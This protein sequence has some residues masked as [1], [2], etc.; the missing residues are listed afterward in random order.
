MNKKKKQAWIEKGYTLVA[1]KG[2]KSL[3]I[4]VIC[5]MMDKSKSSF[6]HYFGDLEMFEEDLVKYHLERAHGFAA[7]IDN[8][9]RA[10]PNFIA[11]LL[12]H[13]LDIFFYKAFRM[14][15]RGP[16]FDHYHQKIFDLYEGA[17][18]EKWA[19]HFDLENKMMLLAQFNKFLSEH[20]ILSISFDN[21]THDWVK[22]YLK[23]VS[24]LVRQMKM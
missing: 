18:L 14:Q 16:I 19:V 23:E 13:K 6:Y 11:V 9:H 8:C 10:D 15:G 4:N 17:I 5:R 21:Y 20:F 12:D 2:F 1:E 3:S 22:N 7:S 24:E